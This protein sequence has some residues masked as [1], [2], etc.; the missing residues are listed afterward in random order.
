[1]QQ[2]TENMTLN[3]AITTIKHHFI[4]S[5]GLLSRIEQ[6]GKI[7]ERD[8]H[9]IENSLGRIRI[10]WS[11]EQRVPKNIV[12][13]FIYGI[14]KLDQSVQNY[15]DQLPEITNFSMKLSNWIN[16]IFSTESMTE[17]YAL[18]L[19]IQHI[20]GT[21]PFIV[22]LRQ[23]RINDASVSE[24]LEALGVLSRFWAGNSDIPK[25]AA[26]ALFNA[27]DLMINARYMFT[28]KDLEKLEN[29]EEKMKHLVEQCLT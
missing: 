2:D 7:D 21:P 13:M 19:F 1:M 16:N 27:E 14:S 6:G 17:E 5:S 15:G 4:E 26:H 11:C 12:M 23:N 29:I 9:M 20:F 8:V 28:G 10:E 22:E 24:L 25:L 18:S 3:D